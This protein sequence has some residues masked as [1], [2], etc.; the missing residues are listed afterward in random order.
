MRFLEAI[1]RMLVGMLLCLVLLQAGL[2][3]FMK[4][5]ED[6]AQ[7]R[8]V[9]N[10]STVESECGKNIFSEEVYWDL[11]AQNN[12]SSSTCATSDCEFSHLLWQRAE[13]SSDLQLIA[14]QSAPPFRWG[15]MEQGGSIRVHVKAS[16]KPQILAL[17]S[18][19]RLEWNF[20]VDEG[21]VIEKVIVA[22]PQIVWLQGLPPKTAIEYLPKEKMCSYPYAWEEVF[23]PDNELRT[24][25]NVLKKITGLQVTSFQG[26]LVGKE[27]RIPL[28]D[29]EHG[30][31]TRSLASTDEK[32]LPEK[33]AT[34]SM[35]VWKREE[36]RI[37]PEKLKLP[38][39]EILFPEK[40]QA[41]TQLLGET[42]ILRDHQLWTW[43]TTTKTF[44]KVQTPK[45]LPPLQYVTAVAPHESAKA[46]YLYNDERGGEMFRYDL[47]KKEWRL[48]SSGYNFYIEALYFD[49]TAGKLHA[50]ASQG[51][52]LTQ[53]LTLD[54]LSAKISQKVPLKNKV[55]FDRRHWKWQLR[56]DK[57]HFWMRFFQPVA[58]QGADVLLEI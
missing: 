40:T 5:M 38:T 4:N 56:K 19:N 57:E 12:L 45:I 24:V 48:L 15:D 37:L 36:Q 53:L 34:Q 35:L 54:P 14:V 50:V 6:Q 21:A 43:N 55:A 30:V 16:P 9:Q 10:T 52:Y 51:A 7:F 33:S 39:G 17:V 8:L 32:P 13:Q 2:V 20:Q 11:L 25:M 28:F 1:N 18:R 46:L 41:V 27:F 58:V 42:F 22:T 44:E 49:E 29:M 26:A 31:V 47:E 23:N 3:F